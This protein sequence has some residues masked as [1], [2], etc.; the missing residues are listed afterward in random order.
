MNTDKP[1]KARLQTEEDLRKTAYWVRTDFESLP[2][3]D[4]MYLDG[5]LLARIKG[6]SLDYFQHEFTALAIPYAQSRAVHCLDARKGVGAVLHRYDFRGLPLLVYED[7][8][9]I[10]VRVSVDLGPPAE[11]AAAAQALA[12]DL[13]ARPQ[14]LYFFP[15]LGPDELAQFSTSPGQTIRPIDMQR[16]VMGG[17]V[18][19]GIYFV[20]AKLDDYPGA[21]WFGQRGFVED[22]DIV[23]AWESWKSSPGAGP[24][25][26][27]PP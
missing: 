10:M 18:T 11:E 24:P 7:R 21:P 15:P 20:A 5:P 6:A 13:L 12:D 23:A 14:Q 22:D 16:G 27:S 1:R 2:P 9:Y 4:F 19:G 17:L 26:K 3:N 25:E 8:F